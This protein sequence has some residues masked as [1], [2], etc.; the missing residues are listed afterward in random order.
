MLG[1]LGALCPA[2]RLSPSPKF[3]PLRPEKVVQ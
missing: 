1:S 3:W 2:E